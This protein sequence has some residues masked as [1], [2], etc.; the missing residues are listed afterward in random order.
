MIQSNYDPEHRFFLSF[1]TDPHDESGQLVSEVRVS[2]H[3][4]SRIDDLDT[5]LTSLSMLTGRFDENLQHLIE[6]LEEARQQM[7]K[8]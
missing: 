3:L 6:E 2:S 5:Y 7:Q 4:L 8:P 1:L